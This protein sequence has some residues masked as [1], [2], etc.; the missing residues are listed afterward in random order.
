MST[1]RPR[2]PSGVEPGPTCRNCGSRVGGN[3]CAVCGQATREKRG[4]LRTLLANVASEF[5][6]IDGRHARTAAALFVPGRL[7]ERYL[8]GKWA[9]YVTPV[10]VYLV[11]SLLFFLVVGFP[12]PNADNYNVYVDDVLVGREEPEQGLGH[13]QLAGFGDEG[14]LAEQAERHWGDK[15]ERLQAM[16][17]QALLDGYFN[18]LERVV[19]TTLIAFVPIL[20]A[21]LSLLYIR[22]SFYYVDHLVFALHA[23]GFLFLLFVLINLLTRLGLSLFGFSFLTYL[24][25]F[26]AIGPIYLALALRRVYRQGWVRTLLK[27]FLLGFAYLILIQPILM[28]TFF[29]VLESM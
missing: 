16:P 22:R 3:F 11:L 17:A 15:L 4:P 13:L 23:Q 2:T 7:T 14:W 19:P 1:E 20:A 21:A 12:A 10:R 27:T 28:L 5:L 26:F 25:A 9:S 29:W 18:E 24:L 6:S 8:Q